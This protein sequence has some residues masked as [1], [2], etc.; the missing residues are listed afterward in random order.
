MP[1]CLDGVT[2]ESGWVAFHG[3]EF[4]T[5]AHGRPDQ[6]RLEL[7]GRIGDILGGHI[8]VERDVQLLHVHIRHREDNENAPF[9]K[10]NEV[11]IANGGVDMAG[12]NNHG[13]VPSDIG[14]LGGNLFV[15]RLQFTLH[16]ADERAELLNL[17]G[18]QLASPEVVD[19]VAVA[20]LGRHAT[21][22]RV[23]LVEIPGT[24]Q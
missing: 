6:K 8:K 12:T 21:G 16:G 11:G 14:E 18:R 24:F 22:R 10:I 20:L 2:Y 13:R 1:D 4:K 23:G 9:T 15:D 3:R 17:G 7:L 19:K 5:I